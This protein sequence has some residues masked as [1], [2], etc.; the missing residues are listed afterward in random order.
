MYVAV[1]GAVLCKMKAIPKQKW[2]MKSIKR[3]KL[4]IRKVYELA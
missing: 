2:K 1:F 3:V 4:G